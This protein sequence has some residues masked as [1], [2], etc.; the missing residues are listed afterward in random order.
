MII[1]ASTYKRSTKFCDGWTN[2]VRSYCSKAATEASR[3]VRAGTA[4]PIM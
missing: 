1:L 3:T 2:V 4:N